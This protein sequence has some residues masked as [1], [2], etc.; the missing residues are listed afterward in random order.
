MEIK[1]TSFTG[2]FIQIIKWRGISIIL[3]TYNNSISDFARII[4]FGDAF[5]NILY[6][7]I[8]KYCSVFK[9]K[10]FKD[11]IIILINNVWTKNKNTSF[12]NIL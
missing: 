12:L 3:V 1:N 9:F 10:S 6:I 7:N 8:L 11:K 4:I 5:C 2:K